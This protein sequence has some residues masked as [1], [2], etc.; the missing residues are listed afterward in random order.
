MPCLGDGSE[1]CGGADRVLIYTKNP[2]DA[3]V[4]P[5]QDQ[6]G[7]GLD[8]NFKDGSGNWHCSYPVFSGEDPN[9]FFCRYSVTTGALLQDHN[10]GLCFNL[11]KPNNCAVTRRELKEREPVLQARVDIEAAKASKLATASSLYPD[12]DIP[13]E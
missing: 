1:Y 11:A 4:C 2:C 9:D 12:L 6:A 8:I 10:A 5:D 13:Q 3:F 7:F